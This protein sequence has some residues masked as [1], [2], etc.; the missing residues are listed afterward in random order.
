VRGCL[1]N[2]YSA[3]AAAV[4]K[5]QLHKPCA[6]YYFVSLYMRQFLCTLC[7]KK[8]TDVAHYN[9]NAYQ[10]I[11]VIFGRDVAERVCYRTVFV[12]PPLMANVSALPGET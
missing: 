5:L 6:L 1:S 12:I 8:D 9:L 11:L 2:L 7:L 3:S 4:V 10:P